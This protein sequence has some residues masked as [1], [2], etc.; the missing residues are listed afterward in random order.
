MTAVVALTTIALAIPAAA[1]AAVTHDVLTINKTGGTNVK[2]GAV[3]KANLH[4]GTK[5]VFA[6]G[7][8][9]NV[10]CTVSSFS[11]KVTKNPAK[12]GTALES[13]TAQTF[14]K[15]KSTI[16]N[17]RSVKSVKLNHLP[18]KTTI[19]DAAGF[20]VTVAAA[21]TTITL[22]TTLGTLSCT[23]KSTT[24]TKGSASNTSQ[25]ITFTKQ[26]FKLSSGPR[27]CPRKGTFSATYGP[28]LDTSVTGSPHVFVN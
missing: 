8:A 24:S 1:S 7:S 5:V 20:P 21:S 14:S 19:S 25:T 18:Y 22:N 12:P 3:L 15:C 13:L 23:Y 11:V 6:A 4:S 2:V 9:G 27:A 10:T 17:T 26:P 16:S 28:V